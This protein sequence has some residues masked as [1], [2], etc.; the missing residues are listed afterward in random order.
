MSKEVIA[1]LIGAG[2]AIIAAFVALLKRESKKKPSTQSQP[3]GPTV[4]SSQGVIIA[5][6][7]STVIQHAEPAKLTEINRNLEHIRDVLR[8]NLPAVPAD[9]LDNVQEVDAM[10]HP[11]KWRSLPMTRFTFPR[12]VGSGDNYL[13]EIAGKLLVRYLSYSAFRAADGKF[14]RFIIN[15]SLGESVEAGNISIHFATNDGPVL[16]ELKQLF[17]RK[18]TQ[19]TLEQIAATLHDWE[20]SKKFAI[21]RSFSVEV[22]LEPDQ[23][24]VSFRNAPIYEGE[25][26][27]SEVIISQQVLQIDETAARSIQASVSKTLAFLGRVSLGQTVHENF[28]VHYD[29]D[30]QSLYKPNFL[31]LLYQLL[32]QKVVAYDLFR[33]SIDDPEKWDYMYHHS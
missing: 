28:I 6:E 8:T 14:R 5:T 27:A 13:S 19:K 10:I 26:T 12:P 24:L 17:D 29:L 33:I 9:Q 16:H 15:L 22:T 2:G 4:Q 30:G 20:F 32:D 23:K 31:R 3:T 18:Q 7:G 1:A 25:D 11:N 21:L